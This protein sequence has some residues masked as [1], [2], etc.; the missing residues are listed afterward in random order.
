MHSIGILKTPWRHGGAALEILP[1]LVFE[2]GLMMGGPR[3]KKLKKLATRA[4]AQTMHGWRC[5]PRWIFAINAK[6]FP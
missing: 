2:D 1:S 3:Q 5:G 4:T 6:T